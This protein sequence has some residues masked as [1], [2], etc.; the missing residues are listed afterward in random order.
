MALCT[1]AILAALL[2][3]QSMLGVDLRTVVRPGDT[4][5]D[6][7]WSYRVGFEALQDANPGVDVWL[8]APGTVLRLPTRLVLPDGPADGLVLNVPEMRLFDYRAGPVPDVY[9]VAV[10]DAEDPTPIGDFTVGKREVDPTWEVPAD[11]QA[12]KP[13]L[14]AKVPPGPDNPLGSRWMGLAGPGLDGSF[15][16]HGTNVKWSIGREATHGCVRL[17][18]DDVERLYDRTPLGTPVHIIYQPIK[19]GRSGR[20]LY[21]E[22]HPDLYGRMGDPT[23]E[24]LRVGRSLGRI[25]EG[26]VRRA[27]AEARGV[28]IRVGTLPVT[29]GSGG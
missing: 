7:A 13:W 11:I 5:L 10:G 29:S 26:A 21:V 9:A 22:V 18:E 16:L 24:A 2:A 12:A 27:V 28:P 1:W 8:P 19:W 3:P 25:D 14:P 17:Y 4:L 6:I 15:G 23:E 20:D